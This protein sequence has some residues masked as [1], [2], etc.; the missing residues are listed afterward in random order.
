MTM[1][2]E[3]LLVNRLSTWPEPENVASPRVLVLTITSNVIADIILK[4][5]NK[6]QLN[7]EK[8]APIQLK[9]DV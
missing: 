7:C 8:A 2:I 3:P 4:T 5:K 1:C 6:A 9:M